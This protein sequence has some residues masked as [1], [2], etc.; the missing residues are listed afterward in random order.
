MASIFDIFTNDNARD[1]SNAQIA[2]INAGQAGATSNINQAISS[3][4]GNYGAGANALNTNF[5]AALQPFLQN[6][7]TANAGVTQLGNVLGL[8]G[9]GGND[10]A[11]AALQN[12]PGYQ[13]ALKSGDDAI[14]AAEAA[15][16]KNFSGNQLIDLSKFNQGLASQNYNNYVGQ[17][18]PFL[19]AQNASASGIGNIY[20]GLGSS[21]NANSIGLGNA[22][23]NQY[24]TLGNLSWNANTGIGNANANADLA[25][26]QASKNIWGALGAISP[27]ASSIAGSFGGGGGG[28]AGPTGFG[29]GSWSLGGSPISSS[30][31]SALFSMFSDERLKEDIEPVGKL[32]DGQNVYS[33]RYKGDH[34]PRIGLMAQEVEQINPDAVTEIA[35]FKAVDYGK[36]TRYAAD[37]S[38]F[39]EA[40]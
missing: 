17:L 18:E 34:V 21:L 35:G 31:G 16:G 25:Q 4:T 13:F 1:A 7:K 23:A 33:Y 14:N 27:L 10:A 9:Q 15:S 38:R 19:Q 26:N 24:D 12:T 2:G 11:M 28:S 3:L 29:G 8:N 32:F 6:N 36:A 40:A 20:T 30:M 39:L 5:T 37:L 22:T